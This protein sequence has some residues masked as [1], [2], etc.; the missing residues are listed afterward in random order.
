[1][2]TIPIHKLSEVFD[3]NNAFLIHVLHNEIHSNEE[4]KQIGRRSS[5][6]YAHRDDY[7]VF[8]LVKEGNGKLTID[9]KEYDLTAG[10]IH[11]IMQDR[12]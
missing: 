7:Y 10:T 2:N 12:D 3:G 8:F 11:C 6:N 5:N 4:F 9:F 1:M